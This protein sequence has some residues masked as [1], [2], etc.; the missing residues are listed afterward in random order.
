MPELDI[1]AIR[2]RAGECDVLADT[3]ALCDEVERLREEN[4]RL[5]APVAM[6]EIKAALATWIDDNDAAPPADV[7]GGVLDEFLAGRRGAGRD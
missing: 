3:Y 7:M 5:A 1:D 4:A 2:D 6:T